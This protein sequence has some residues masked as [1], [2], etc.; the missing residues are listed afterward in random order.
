MRYKE[1]CRKG[2]QGYCLEELTAEINECI[3]ALLKTNRCS[4][5]KK[6]DC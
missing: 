2:H 3:S 5:T 1:I 4:A 6:I